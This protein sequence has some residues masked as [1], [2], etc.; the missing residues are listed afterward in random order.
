MKSTSGMAGRD[1][2]GAHARLP[3]GEPVLEDG[4]LNVPGAPSDGPT[5]PSKFSERNAAL[6][7]AITD[8]SH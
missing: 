5:A 8:P 2:P 4:R 7:G 3:D 1:E 6:A